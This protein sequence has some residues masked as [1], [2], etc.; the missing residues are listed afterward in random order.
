MYQERMLGYYPKVI[1]SI[2][3]Y[4]VILQT[5]SPEIEGI[6]TKKDT[7]LSDAYLLTMSEGRIKQWESILGINVSEGSTLEDR[8]ETIIARIRGQGKLNTALINTIVKTFTGAGCNSW[9]EDST[10]FIRLLPPKISNK[11]Y[12]I[13]NIR[14]EII[15]KVPA[16]IK[17]DLDKAWQYWVDVNNGYGSWSQVKAY[18][19]N[20]EDVL[21]NQVGKPNALDHSG[22]DY[23]FYLD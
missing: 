4:Q 18:Y 5:E 1:Q 7:V 8:R 9:F 3:E 12:I 13:D 15:A 16:H 11:E 21:Y 19:G 14:Q 17:L 10:L 6:N 22:L 20:W 23:D 2:L